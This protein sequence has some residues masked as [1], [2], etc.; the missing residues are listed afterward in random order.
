MPFLG[1][2]YCWMEPSMYDL[3]THQAARSYMLDAGRKIWVQLGPTP[4]SELQKMSRGRPVA[5]RHPLAV[6][7]QPAHAE[8]NQCASET[9]SLL[10]PFDS[11]IYG[12]RWGTLLYAKAPM[13]CI[14]HVLSLQHTPLAGTRC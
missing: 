7:L 9:S 6:K 3:G 5:P 11:Q 4:P 2:W 10:D 13:R 8:L 12:C 1:P 14:Y